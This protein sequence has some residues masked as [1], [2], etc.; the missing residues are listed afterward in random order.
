MK[1]PVLT[2]AAVHNLNSKCLYQTIWQSR[3]T[4]KTAIVLK[5]L[6]AE[7]FVGSYDK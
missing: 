3:K 6:Y 1:L 4:N 5:V 2:D 7:G